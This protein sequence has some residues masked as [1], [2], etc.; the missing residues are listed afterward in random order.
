MVGRTEVRHIRRP[1]WF[2]RSGILAIAVTFVSL[3]ACGTSEGNSPE[4]E[5]S[6]TPSS[7][8]DASGGP[9]NFQPTHRTLSDLVRDAVG[10][11]SAR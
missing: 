9:E 11:F 4:P 10:F 2:S 3:V 5:I 1:H 7:A 8:A 6:Q